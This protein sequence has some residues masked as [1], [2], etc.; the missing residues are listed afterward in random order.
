MKTLPCNAEELLPHRKA[1]LLIDSLDQHEA[2]KAAATAKVNHANI[3]LDNNGGLLPEYFIEIIAQTAAAASGFAGLQ[4]NVP[5]R[6][7][8][9]VGIENFSVL[10]H[11]ENYDSL[12]I[13]TCKNMQLGHMQVID[14][15]VFH[16]TT[17]IAR[18]QLKLWQEGEQESG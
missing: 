12:R 15:E 7:G 17:C 6:S 2:D 18:A 14:G 11:G 3:F 9:L 4:Q 16:G 8:Y 5:V 1:M 10:E 13:E